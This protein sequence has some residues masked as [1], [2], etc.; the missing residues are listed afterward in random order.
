M[1][2]LTTFIILDL[3]LPPRWSPSLEWCC[4]WLDSLL[5]WTD[6]QRWKSRPNQK[7]ASIQRSSKKSFSLTIGKQSTVILNRDPEKSQLFLQE[8]KISRLLWRNTK[9]RRTT[10]PVRLRCSFHWQEV[11]MM[12]V[13]ATV[14][15]NPDPEGQL[16]ITRDLVTLK[17]TFLQH[18]LTLPLNMKLKP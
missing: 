5:P 11:S 14:T 12:T 7:S 3:R 13:P 6:W 18:L 17:I 8:S 2:L 9:L 10:A 15:P 16:R 4:P 1:V